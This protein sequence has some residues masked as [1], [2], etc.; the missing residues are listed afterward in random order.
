[1]TSIKNM[2]TA[3]VLMMG[4]AGAMTALSVQEAHAKGSSSSSGGR[5]GSVSRSYSSSPSSYSR[6]TSSV[7]RTTPTVVK[8]VAS[9]PISTVKKPVMAS[10]TKPKPYYGSAHRDDDVECS[11]LRNSRHK[12]DREVFRR[13]C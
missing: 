2:G 3:A 1:M 13:Y 6:P 12:A 5:S 9:R 11:T 8:P 10:A 4:I 7:V